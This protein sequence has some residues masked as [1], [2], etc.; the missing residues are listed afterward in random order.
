MYIYFYFYLTMCNTINY[1]DLKTI[2][3]FIIDT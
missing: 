3:S 2:S 1:L